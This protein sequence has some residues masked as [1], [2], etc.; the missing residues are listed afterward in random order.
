MCIVSNIYDKWSPN[1]PWKYPDSPLPNPWWTPEKIKEFMGLIEAAKKQDKAEGNPDCHKPEMEE[2]IK[3]IKTLKARLTK[4]E[5]AAKQ[6][7]KRSRSKALA[8]AKEEASRLQKTKKA[9]LV[10]LRRK[11]VK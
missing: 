1:Q 6:P 3:E 8:G 7:S 2:F 11:T 4:L 5:E 10:K 9:V